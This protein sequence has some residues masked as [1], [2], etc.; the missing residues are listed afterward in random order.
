MK[1]IVLFAACL[2]LCAGLAFAQTPKKPVNA[3]KNAKEA[4]TKDVKKTDNVETSNTTVKHDCGNCPNAKKCDGNKMK[5]AT[6]PSNK[7]N[8]NA[9]GKK[10]AFNTKAA[11]N[12]KTAQNTETVK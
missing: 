4:T 5:T 3:G 9:N 6:P 11:Q 10:D 1:K 2:T 12:T 7:D 8:K